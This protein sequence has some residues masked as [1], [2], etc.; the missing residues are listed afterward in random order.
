M[1]KMIDVNSSNVQ[2]IGY[3]TRKRE[4]LVTFKDDTR[5][6][7]YLKVPKLVWTCFQKAGSKGSFLQEYVI[8]YFEFTR[9]KAS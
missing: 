9:Q 4:L 1:V 3:D 6:Y 2:S 7:T 8:P 5:L